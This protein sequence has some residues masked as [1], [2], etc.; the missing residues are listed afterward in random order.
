MYLTRA[1]AEIHGSRDD[2]SV[3][4]AAVFDRDVQKSLENSPPLQSRAGRKRIDAVPGD[5]CKDGKNLVLRA[6]VRAAC[7]APHKATP[8][9]SRPTAKHADLR[10]FARGTWTLVC[11]LCIT[12]WMLCAHFR[13]MLVLDVPDPPPPG[14]LACPSGHGCT[15]ARKTSRTCSRHSGF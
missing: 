10:P 1:R 15:D 4:R 6:L 9:Q 14:D 5:A 3:N 13:S 7:A 8:C 2:V 12:L 11:Y